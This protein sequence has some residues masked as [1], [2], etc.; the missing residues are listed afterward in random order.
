MRV[1]DASDSSTEQSAASTQEFINEASLYQPFLETIRGD[2]AKTNSIRDFVCEITAHQ[3]RRDT[4]GQWTRPDVTFIAVRTYPFIPGKKLEVITFEIKPIGCYGIEGVFETASHSVIAN[5]SYLAL[6]VP[7]G[8]DESKL[9]RIERRVE[10]FRIGLMTFVDP[11]SLETF[12]TIIEPA[13]HVLDPAL[14][15]DFVN[16][17]LNDDNKDIL[18][19][20]IR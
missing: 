2:W 7:Q 11:T 15:S 1:V 6:H 12:N 17:Q 20:L 3:G 5:K 9:E 19:N 13:H 16:L 8:F 10:H 14:T 4:G 18:H